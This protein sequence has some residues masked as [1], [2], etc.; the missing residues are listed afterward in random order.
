MRP[1]AIL[2]DHSTPSRLELVLLLVIPTVVLT[3]PS[4]AAKHKQRV[5]AGSDF[6]SYTETIPGTAVTFEMEPVQG[7][8]FLMGSPDDEPGRSPDEGPRHSVAV[9]AFWIGKTEVTWDEYDQFAFGRRET[10]ATDSSAAQKGIDALT[11]PTP[12]YA[13][14]SFGYGKGR[15]PVISITHHAA[16]EYC[17]WLSSKTGKI[18]RLPTEAEWEYASRAGSKTSFAFGADSKLLGEYAWYRDNSK[19][20]P[21]PVGLKKPNAWGLC[22]MHGNVG[23]WCVDQYDRGFYGNSKPGAAL[24]GPVLLPGEKRYPHVVRGGSWDDDAKQLRCAARR[25]SVAAWSRRDPQNPQS[26]WWHTEATFV[27]FRVVRPVEEQENLKGLRSRV[28]RSSP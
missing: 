26:I 8:T 28:T 5:A 11:Q 24:I 14:E 25:A 20:E 27:G 19:D 17:R 2:R 3:M 23:E 6:K 13:D 15:R 12:P 1:A 9:R 4:D 7:G 22:D 18:Y 21:H 16:M 10:P